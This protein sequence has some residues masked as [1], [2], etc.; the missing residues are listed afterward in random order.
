M[1]QQKLEIHHHFILHFS[2]QRLKSRKAQRKWMWF[3][4][5]KN[6]IGRQSRVVVNAH[7]MLRY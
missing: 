7:P 4:K 3:G 5:D 1:F 6:G 2:S